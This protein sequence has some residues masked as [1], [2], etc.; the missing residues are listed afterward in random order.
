MIPLVILSMLYFSEGVC[1]Q[2]NG[3]ERKTRPDRKTKNTDILQLLIDIGKDT[4]SPSEAIR[5]QF[6]LKNVSKEVLTV[7]Q[8]SPWRDYTLDVTTESGEGVPFTELGIRLGS[9]RDGRS[10]KFIK[11]E[12][13][14][15]LVDSLD[16]RDFYKLAS[17]GIYIIKAK[18][19]IY[20]GEGKQAVEAV[21]NTLKIKISG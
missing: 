21:S 7:K 10:V 15:E 4:F 20:R 18:R 6:H 8:G 5:L 1:A 14:K 13:D 2:T 19:I 12:P 11:L 17:D 3:G 9:M 16:I